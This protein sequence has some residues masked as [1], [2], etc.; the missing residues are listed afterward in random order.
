MA[1]SSM[2]KQLDIQHF[3][4]I[5]IVRGGGSGIEKLDEIEV[6]EAI[7]NLKTA[8]IYGVG[9]EKENLFIRNI[10]DKVIPISF[11]LGT[12]FRDTVNSVIE[13]KS[14]SKAVLVE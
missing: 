1:L 8:W 14:K 2:L 10:A 5:A 13:K 7:T 6:V 11:A 4:I 9:H 3:D 12:Y